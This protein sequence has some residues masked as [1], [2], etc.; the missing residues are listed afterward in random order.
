MPVHDFCYG[1]PAPIIVK[2]KEIGILSMETKRQIA[3][4]NAVWE[5]LCA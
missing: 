2:Q 3:G 1:V 4:I 5:K